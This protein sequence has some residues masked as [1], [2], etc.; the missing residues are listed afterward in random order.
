MTREQKIQND[1]R[2]ALSKNKCTVF[3]VNVGSV[4]TPDGRFFSADV[5]KRQV[6]CRAIDRDRFLSFCY[7]HIRLSYHQVHQRGARE[8]ARPQDLS[9]IH[10]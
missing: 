5:Y 7:I 10:I 9:L 6:Q 8:V 1:I 4:R 2:V 3:R